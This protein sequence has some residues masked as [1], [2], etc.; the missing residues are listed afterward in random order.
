MVDA[1]LESATRYG[2]DGHEI[3]RILLVSGADLNYNTGEWVVLATR[4]AFVGSLELLLGLWDDRG[5]QKK[6]SQPTLVRALKAC[7]GLE[8]GN[9]FRVVSSL[10]KA[11]L[12]ATDDLHIALNDAINKEDAEERLI[13]LL[14]TARRPQPTDAR[15]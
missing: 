9:C 13:K 15:L 3:L 14:I 12:Q 2:D 4:S 10:I 7:W 11:G 6:V 8:R 1:Q 5:N